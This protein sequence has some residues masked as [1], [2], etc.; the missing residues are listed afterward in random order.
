M[1]SGPV[2]FVFCCT[3]ADYPEFKA[4]LP[5][6]LPAT[7]EEFVSIVD[8]RIKDRMQQVTVSKAYVRPAEF[9]AYCVRSGEAP[10]YD[11]LVRCCFLAWGRATGGIEGHD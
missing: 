1:P 6:D 9:V 5:N 7:Y 2:E 4:L 3:E 8:K 10:N 11:A